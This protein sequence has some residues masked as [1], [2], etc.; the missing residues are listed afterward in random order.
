MKLNDKV[1]SI[2]VERFGVDNVMALATICDGMPCVRY[3]NAYYENGAFY[4]ISHELSNKMKQINMD[5]KVGICGEW[6]S[7]QG[8]GVNLGYFGK[9]NNKQIADKLREVFASWIDNGHNDFTDVHTCILK[10]ELTKGT[11]FS[12][13]ERFNI[14]FRKKK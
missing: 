9:E 13:G 5:P 11:L 1:E 7:A 6:F 14:E 4:I 12:H 8:N 10:V 3:V 2:M